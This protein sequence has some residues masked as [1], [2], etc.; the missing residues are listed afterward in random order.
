MSSLEM[1]KQ[2]GGFGD[3]LELRINVLHQCETLSVLIL[4][5]LDDV[6]YL[7]QR[8]IQLVQGVHVLLENFRSLLL[9]LLFHDPY[10]QAVFLLSQVFEEPQLC[11]SLN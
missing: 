6:P 9:I 2:R 10:L 4:Q 5:Q 8:W 1:S 11:K 7:W 3:T